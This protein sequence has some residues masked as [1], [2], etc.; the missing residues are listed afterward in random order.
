[1]TCPPTGH[2]LRP[3][4]VGL[5][6]HRATSGPVFVGRQYLGVN[7]YELN[8]RLAACQ[9]RGRNLS[10]T[11]RSSHEDVNVMCI[12]AETVWPWLVKDVMTSHLEARFSTNEDFQRHIRALELVCHQELRAAD[13]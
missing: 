11:S 2:G 3:T 8:K 7:G 13:L 6:K 9:E 4:L 12:G 5:L 10:P 1:M